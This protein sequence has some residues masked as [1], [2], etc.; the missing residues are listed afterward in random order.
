MVSLYTIDRRVREIMDRIQNESDQETG[1]IPTELWVA[2]DD[3]LAQQQDCLADIACALK[4]QRAEAEA[5]RLEA[6][7]LTE[8]ARALDA[9]VDRLT[10]LLEERV[11]EDGIRDPR[12]TV[13]WYKRVVVDVMVPPEQLPEEYVRVRTEINKIELKRALDLGKEIPGAAL[14]EARGLTIR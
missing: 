1:A 3:L 6:R 13:R 14:G 2:L 9:R 4:E 10:A 5:V 8:R 7:S 12:V 11:G